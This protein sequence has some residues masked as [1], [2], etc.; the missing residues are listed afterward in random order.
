MTCQAGEGS[1]DLKYYLKSCR[2]VDIDNKHVVG[3]SW[4]AGDPPLS[5]FTME[6]CLGCKGVRMPTPHGGVGGTLK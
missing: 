5:R 1:E 4:D 6:S 3:L 2:R